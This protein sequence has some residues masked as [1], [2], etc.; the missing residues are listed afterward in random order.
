[1][2]LKNDYD[3]VEGIITAYYD[4]VLVAAKSMAR[5]RRWQDRLI[6]NT[7]CLNITCKIGPSTRQYEV[8]FLGIEYQWEATALKWR[9]LNTKVEQWRVA[10]NTSILRTSVSAGRAL[11]VREIVIK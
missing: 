1:M 11:G 4:N 2:E 3:E 9:L 6:K 8:G 10:R 7:K 5:V